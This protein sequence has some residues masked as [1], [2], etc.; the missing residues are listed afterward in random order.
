MKKAL[1]KYFGEGWHNLA[2]VILLFIGTLVHTGIGMG[3]IILYLIGFGLN[4]Q[5]QF[6]EEEK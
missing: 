6:D 1:K 3:F 2:T 4:K 5:G